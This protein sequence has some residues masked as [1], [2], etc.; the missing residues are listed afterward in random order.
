MHFISN[1]TLTRG[2]GPWPRGWR[3]LKYTEENATADMARSTGL[4]HCQED[5]CK[6]GKHPK[7]PGG[8]DP[9]L[10]TQG[11]TVQ[12]HTKQISPQF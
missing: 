9:V 6:G 11:F 8:P 5:T 2:T 12:A 4:G 1:L 10:I 3:P 7:E